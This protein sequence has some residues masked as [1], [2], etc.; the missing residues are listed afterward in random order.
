MEAAYLSR[1]AAEGWLLVPDVV[2]GSDCEMLSS[3]IGRPAG[4]HGRGG[5]RGLFAVPAVAALARSLPLRGLVEPV[6]GRDAF[7]VRATLFDKVPAANWR[8]PWHRDRL[9]AVRRRI[10]V[11]GFTAW[12]VKEGIEHT[13]PPSALLARM[14]AVRVHLDAIDHGNGPLRLIPGSHRDAADHTVDEAA[15]VTITAARGSALLMRPLVRHASSPAMA[16]S[17]R[18]VLHLEFAAEEL[19]GGLE[20]RDRW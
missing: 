13:E 14:L 11:P 16:P 5:M 17:R 15:V 1:F 10:D 4:S 6:L 9:V 8:V 19:P 18:R 12:S 2:S 20:W 3:A 7:A